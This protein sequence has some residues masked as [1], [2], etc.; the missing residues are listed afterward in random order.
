MWSFAA[1]FRP[2]LEPAWSFGL[3]ALL[4]HSRRESFWI[5][6]DKSDSR[7]RRSSRPEF[8]RHMT[9]R[10]FWSV[11]VSMPLNLHPKSMGSSWVSSCERLSRSQNDA[12]RIRAAPTVSTRIA[13]DFL[14]ASF[15]HLTTLLEKR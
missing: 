8:T 4:V 3:A 15:G 7:K 11:L 6:C 9:L 5:S 10:H 14:S 2:L 13:A 12:R 1:M